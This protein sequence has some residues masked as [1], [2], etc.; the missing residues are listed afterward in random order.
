LIGELFLL[1]AVFV[2][3]RQIR[4]LSRNDTDAA[5]AN[6]D[7]VVELERRLH[8]FSERGVQ[9][10]VMHSD[11]IVGFLN[12]YYVAVHFSLTTAFLV[13]VYVRHQ[14][15]YRRIRTWF[16]S[17]TMTALVVHVLYPLAPPRM[18]EGPGF[19]DT[20]QRYGPRIYSA[21]TTQSIANQF[22][23]MP[24]LHFGWAVMVAGAFV[25]IRRTRR[26]LLALV[27]P[28]ITLL[29]IVATA[30]HYWIDAAVALVIVAAAALVIHRC[31]LAGASHS[32]ARWTHLSLS[33]HSTTSC[34]SAPT[35]R[36]RWR[37][38]S[39][40]SA[41]RPCASTNGDAARRPSPRFAS[42]PRR[43]SI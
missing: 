41:W 35:S 28:T 2:S 43:S 40:C 27:H 34:W 12:R 10:L 39:M 20:L 31:R 14:R 42:T 18:L 38:T 4:F 24:S 5:M 6:A 36:S 13:W 16:V 33:P 11:L 22:A 7:R 19:V 9:R 8:V 15:H 3:Y 26:S 21:D 23:A 32:L 29:A 37:G 30:N 17:V 1:G 25:S